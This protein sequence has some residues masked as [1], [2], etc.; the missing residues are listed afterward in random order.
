MAG[1]LAAAVS[2]EVGVADTAPFD[3]GEDAWPRTPPRSP[4]SSPSTAPSCGVRGILSPPAGVGMSPRRPVFVAV[5]VRVGGT[6]SLALALL[7]LDG[8]VDCALQRAA[9]RAHLRLEQE[10]LELGRERIH[11][12][13]R[14]RKLAQERER[15]AWRAVCGVQ[16]RLHLRCRW[17]DVSVLRV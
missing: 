4:S 5:G 3:G 16:E 9:V 7:A 2:E 14:G 6:I 1:G 11:D 17:R 8:V 13:V 12:V 15:R 10:V